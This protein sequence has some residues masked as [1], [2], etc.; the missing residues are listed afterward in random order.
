MLLALQAPGANAAASVRPHKQQNMY[1]NMR[2]RVRPDA[3]DVCSGFWR[4]L[5]SF[6]SNKS[7]TTCNS[8]RKRQTCVFASTDMHIC[9]ATLCRLDPAMY[10]AKTHNGTANAARGNAAACDAAL[11]C[12]QNA[13]RLAGHFSVANEVGEEEALALT[14]SFFV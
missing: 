10:D 3:L 14:A 9:S 1:N 8:N 13:A 7:H 11:R 12:C 4:R 6:D 5:P 2:K